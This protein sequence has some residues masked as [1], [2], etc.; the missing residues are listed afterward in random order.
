MDINSPPEFHTQRRT[1]SQGPIKGPSRA[2]APQHSPI[3]TSNE[4]RLSTTG[5]LKSKSCPPQPP[6][7]LPPLPSLPYLVLPCLPCPALLLPSLSLPA[8]P[9]PV[10]PQSVIHALR[11]ALCSQ[12]HAKRQRSFQSSDFKLQGNRSAP[13]RK[14]LL[15]AP[16]RVESRVQ[17]A[18]STISPNTDGSCP[19]LLALHEQVEDG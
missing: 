9:C 13:R 4:D 15:I 17:R 19:V 18:I 11:R 5:L 3:D 16:V 2:P 6:S 1:T 10:L 7:L 12:L 8:L 14:Q